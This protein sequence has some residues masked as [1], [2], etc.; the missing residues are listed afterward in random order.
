MSEYKAKV[1]IGGGAGFIGSHLGKRLKDEGYY[2]VV[3]DWVTNKFMKNDEFCHEFKL[4]DLRDLSSAVEA[5]K[6]CEHIYNLAADMG[7]MGFIQSNQSVLFYNNTMISSNMIEAARRVGVKRFFY[8]SSACVYNESLQLDPN[9]PGLEES[10]AWPARP[11]DTYGL[12]KLYAEEMAIVYAK[13]F[14]FESRVARFH[15]IYG[16]RGTWKGGREK[17]P[18]AFCRKAYCSAS[19]FEMWGDGKQ[20]RSYTFIDDCV[21]GIIRLMRSDCKIPLNLG[22]EE[23]VTMNDFAKLTMKFNGKEL[24]LRHIDGPEGVRGRNSDNKLI[25]K[26]LN[27]EPSVKLADGI[28]R[29]N[30]WI[31]KQ[32]EIDRKAGIDVSQYAVSQ[33]CKQTE[34][35]LDS[36]YDLSNS[37]K[38]KGLNPLLLGGITAVVGGA[39]GFLF[40]KRK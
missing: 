12:E 33:V 27:W 38:K 32:I 37:S 24:P 11:Q 29:T 8:A 6:G 2:V 7:G 9:N 10:M 40:A 20:T 15:N 35:S 30:K 31:G 34:E 3:A 26:H 39:L 4:L 36:A 22:T 18:A 16:P 21:E 23:M 19:D 5:C 25:R 14:G 17:S 13:D 28:A 1:C